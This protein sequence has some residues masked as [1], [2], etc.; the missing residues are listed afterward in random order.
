[1]PLRPIEQDFSATVIIGIRRSG[2]STWP[3]EKM[4]VL[5]NEGVPTESICSIDFSDDRLDFLRREESD[6]AVITEGLHWKTW[7]L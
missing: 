1:M 2:K 5:L 6:P 4:E 7:S 3:H